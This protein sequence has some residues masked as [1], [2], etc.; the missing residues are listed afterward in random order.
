MLLRTLRDPTHVRNPR[1]RPPR[2]VRSVVKVRS[3]GS[4]ADRSLTESRLF[5]EHEALHRTLSVEQ[6]GPSQ[7]SASRRGCFSWTPGEKR[8]GDLNRTLTTRSRRVTNRI[9]RSR[10]PDNSRVRT[11]QNS[12]Q[13]C[14][15]LFRPASISRRDP[16]RWSHQ[17]NWHG[18]SVAPD[19]RS[20]ASPAPTLSLR[21]PQQ[22]HGNLQE[23][24]GV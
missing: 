12:P 16:T 8:A 5:S 9:A 10:A 7:Q 18:E 11:P 17:F 6:S 2:P 19:E 21:I 13:F 15:L 14:K 23:T 3:I 24:G 22:A 4:T 1:R 20:M